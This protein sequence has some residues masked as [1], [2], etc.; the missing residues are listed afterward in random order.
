M[1]GLFSSDIN[2]TASTGD[3][4]NYLIWAILI[5]IIVVII[6]IVIVGVIFFVNRMNKKE[7]KAIEA[8]NPSSSQPP[9]SAPIQV[10][11]PTPAPVTVNPPVVTVNPPVVAA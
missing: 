1:G 6:I 8:P 11:T 10:T 2:Q 4:H 9:N 5:T 7:A 3:A